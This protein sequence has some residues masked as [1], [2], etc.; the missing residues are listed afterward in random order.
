MK[1]LR[2]EFRNFRLLQNVVID[3]STSD[4]K[5]LT[6]IRAE[7]GSGKTSILYGLAW[8]FYGDKGLSADSTPQRLASTAAKPGKA[9]KVEIIIDFEHSPDAFG[10][11]NRYVLIRSR[12]ETPGVGDDFTQGPTRV[13]LLQRTEAGDAPVPGD[14]VEVLEQYVPHRLKDVFLTDGDKVQSFISANVA[15]KD[16]QFRVDSAIRALLGLDNLE[17][18]GKDLDAVAKSFRRDAAASG[19]AD[20][21]EAQRKLDEAEEAVRSVNEALDEANEKRVRIQDELNEVE[22]RFQEIHGVGDIDEINAQ[23]VKA[24]AERDSAIRDHESHLEAIRSLFRSE[25]SLSWALAEGMLREGQKVLSSLADRGIIPGSSVGVLRDRLDI[26][27]C[28]CG[29][30]L[31][32]NSSHR[33]HVLDLIKAQEKVSEEH[34][35]LTETFHATRSGLN[36]YESAVANGEDFWSLRPQLLEQNVSITDRIKS[37]QQRLVASEKL[38]ENLDEVQISNL[39]ARKE[40]ATSDLQ[41]QS[42]LIGRLSADAVSAEDLRVRC[43]E[44]FQELSRAAQRDEAVQQRL[45]IAEDLLHIVNSTLAKLKTEHVGEVSRRMNEIFMQIVGSTPE[46]AGAVFHGAS[47]TDS[48]EIVVEAAGGK[49]LN[50][51]TEVNGASQRALTLSFIWALMEV[52]GVTAP[53]VIDTPL[54]MTAGGVKQR[55]MESITQPADLSGSDYQVV[56]LLTRSEI[57]DIETLLDERAGR[58]VTLSCSKDFP[59][60]LVNDWDVSKPEVR[61]C[62]CSHRQFCGICER[63]VD[64]DDGLLRRG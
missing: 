33:Q 31:D 4:Q 8:A 60:D 23:I 5:P 38:R 55:M 42:E 32:S 63:Q 16:R 64:A 47:I 18:L 9:V 14:P 46:L 28:I 19:G 3:F 35:K 43:D 10:E 62:G 13:Q 40:S 53:R 20:L 6:A 30:S 41:E 25:E 1:L 49:T 36:A 24:R 56:L 11:P 15:S 2:V 61:A 51:A 44:E 34:E 45:G 59:V 50:T 22:R 48:F 21:V 27:E 7:N 58:F 17:E 29:E 57:R 37:S 26:G 54:G 12:E 39:K 52:S